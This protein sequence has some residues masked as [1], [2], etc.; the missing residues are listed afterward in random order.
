MFWGSLS[1]GLPRGWPGQL[2]SLGA[3]EMPPP[4]WQQQAPVLRA[5]LQSRLWADPMPPLLQPPQRLLVW[6]L[7]GVFTVEVVPRVAAIIASEAEQGRA[8]SH[9]CPGP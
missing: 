1:V 6:R 4:P 2:L 3:T 8:G 7:G 9:S 5:S